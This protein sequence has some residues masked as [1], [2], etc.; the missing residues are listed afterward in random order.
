MF[1]LS[2]TA[3]ILALTVTA[4]QAG[5]SLT[6]R[7]HDAAVAACAPEASSSRPASHYRAITQSCV[8]RISNAATVK[9]QAAAEAKT[10]A[11]TDVND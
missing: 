10:K 1:R 2:T 6:T 9:Y 7:I 11:A 4:A 3:A 8:Q 5:E